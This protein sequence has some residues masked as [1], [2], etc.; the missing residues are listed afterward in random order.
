MEKASSR[1]GG[2][3]DSR[4]KGESDTHGHSKPKRL[5]GANEGLTIKGRRVR[6]SHPQGTKRRTTL[7]NVLHLPSLGLLSAS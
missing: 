7:I 4:S 3:G 6:A 1:A 5:G 2:V